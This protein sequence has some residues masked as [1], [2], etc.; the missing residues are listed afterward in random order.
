MAKKVI[1]KKQS[2]PKAFKP[3][4]AALKTAGQRLKKILTILRKS[5]PDAK[6]ALVHRNALDLLVATILSA[7]CTDE[8]VNIVT[9]VLFKKY[10]KADDYVAVELEELQEDIRSTGFY[11]NKGKNIQGACK[12][13]ADEHKGK[14]PDTMEELVKLPGVGRKT[15]NVLL[16]NVFGVPGITTDTHVIRLSRLMGLSKNSD[17]VKLEQDLMKLVPEK[18]WTNFSH[19]IIFHGR[20]V[21]NARKPDCENCLLE[22][23]CCYGK[24]K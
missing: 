6:C 15:A 19:Q 22:T 9:K 18:E 14:V 3:T 5:Y 13:I 12:L 17:P 2:T 8:R 4:A 16:G 23:L 7:Q 21:C 11:K 24:H 20:Q 1:T 10:R